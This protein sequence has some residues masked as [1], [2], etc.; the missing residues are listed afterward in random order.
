MGLGIRNQFGRGG[1]RRI[2][3]GDQ[4]RRRAHRLQNRREVLHRVI[5][6]LLV[7]MRILRVGNDDGVQQGVAVGLGAGHVLRADHGAGARLVVDDDG[8]A[9]LLRHL[10]RQHARQ[11]IRSRA[12]RERH[13]HA[14]RLA[15]CGPGVGLR[16]GSR[17]SPETGQD[18]QGRGA[19]PARE[20]K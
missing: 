5:R 17:D 18:T 1:E 14:Y 7:K 20:M 11:G 13:H 15:R 9:R 16:G 10:R 6:Q 4:H 19:A 3:G 8:C 12:G 2:L